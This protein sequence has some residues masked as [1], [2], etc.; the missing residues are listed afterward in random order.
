VVPVPGLGPDPLDDHGVP[1]AQAQ[2]A[3]GSEPGL[4]VTRIREL[5]QCCLDRA[6]AQRRESGEVDMGEIEEDLRIILR[7]EV[8]PEFV[9]IEFERVMAAVFGRDLL[10][11]CPSVHGAPSSASEAEARQTEPADENC[12]GPDYER[13]VAYRRKKE[14]QLN[15]V[16]YEPSATKIRN[17]N[18]ILWRLLD[19]NSDDARGEWGNRC[20]LTEPEIKWLQGIDRERPVVGDYHEAQQIERRVCERRNKK[21]RER[22]Q[23]QGGAG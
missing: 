4:S 11:A 5:R 12:S 19:N 8:L 9:E 2:P 1:V 16:A 6:E 20:F 7:E 3:N 14:Q 17:L 13:W 23:G 10:A 22:E 15:E 18:L 21:W